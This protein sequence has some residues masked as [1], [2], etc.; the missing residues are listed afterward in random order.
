MSALPQ[1]TRLTEAEYFALLEDSLHRDDG[2][3]Y[4]LID[5]YV[6]AMSGASANHVRITGNLYFALRSQLTGNP[7]E[8][9]DS[10]MS[11]KAQADTH[12]YFPDVSVVCGEAQFVEDAPVAMLLNPTLLIEVL[13]STSELRDRTTKFAAYRRWT[14]CKCMCWSRRMPPT[15]SVTPAVGMARGCTPPRR[16]VRVRGPDA[17]ANVAAVGGCLRARHLPRPRRRQLRR[18]PP[19][20]SPQVNPSV[21][22]VRRERLRVAAGE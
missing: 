15:L 1:D 7:C 6:Y 18:R 16:P 11:V 14:A 22:Q 3:K 13:S 10:D 21:V 12:Y 8:V 4:E 19:R 17:A 5:G 9:F 20:L 2:V